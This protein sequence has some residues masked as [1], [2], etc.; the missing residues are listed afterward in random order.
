M[1]FK[2]HFNRITSGVIMASLLKTE[3]ILSLYA[4]IFNTQSN[5]NNSMINIFFLGVLVFVC[6]VFAYKYNKIIEKQHLI[7]III[8][9]RTI[10]D[11]ATTEFK[12]KYKFEYKPTALRHFYNQSP[13]LQ[14]V[15]SE[16]ENLENIHFN[17]QLDYQLNIE[18]E[19]QQI[20]NQIN[21]KKFYSDIDDLL[22]EI[23]E[24]N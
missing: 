22:N 20:K 17:N 19:K 23:Y 14:D 7:S 1:K 21:T 18:Y 8:N 16:K 2:S 24:P 11:S 15:K 9:K 5:N 6:I 10:P 13:T 4:L 12:E 3:G